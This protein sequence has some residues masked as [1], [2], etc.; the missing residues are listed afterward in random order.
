MK[1]A[2]SKEWCEA[3]AK[4]ED[5]Q[6]IGAGSSDHPLRKL[7]DPRILRTTS[8]MELELAWSKDESV[9]QLMI[10]TGIGTD[11]EQFRKI[12]LTPLQLDELRGFIMDNID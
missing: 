8:G 5:G 1:V 10:T 11:E 2:I 4:L 7:A 6:E 9:T 12:R 3:M